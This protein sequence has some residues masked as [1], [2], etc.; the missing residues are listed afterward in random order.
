MSTLFCLW[1]EVRNLK[2]ECFITFKHSHVLENTFSRRC[3][4]LKRIGIPCCHLATIILWFFEINQ[5]MLVQFC[6]ILFC[7]GFMIRMLYLYWDL[8]FSPVNMSENGNL[9]VSS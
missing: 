8:P 1:I 2:M 7:N 3:A 5:A 4:G 6:L 9:I